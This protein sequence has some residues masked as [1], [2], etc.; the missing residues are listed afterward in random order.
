[1]RHRRGA[2]DGLRLQIQDANAA[3]TALG[4]VVVRNGATGGEIT[5]LDAKRV[6]ISENVVGD[7]NARAQ[8]NLGADPTSLD[9]IRNEVAAVPGCGF[10]RRQHRAVA[11]GEVGAADGGAGADVEVDRSLGVPAKCAICENAAASARL[12]SVKRV[13]AEQA[14]L[15]LRPGARL[16]QDVDGSVLGE[17][18]FPELGRRVR[19]AQN[20]AVDLAVDQALGDDALAAVLGPDAVRVFVEIAERDFALRAVAQKNADGFWRRAVLREE[21]PGDFRLTTRMFHDQ[22]GE[23]ASDEDTELHFRR[24][25]EETNSEVATGIEAALRDCGR[26]EGVDDDAA[27]FER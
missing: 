18:A 22:A 3:I 16:R 11:G 19:R 25:I 14:P 27:L 2:F 8:V 24:A 20:A 10:S 7:G 12:D 23:G 13:T 17:G 5:E 4:D 1:M 21:A 9:K 26:R 6:A 15:N